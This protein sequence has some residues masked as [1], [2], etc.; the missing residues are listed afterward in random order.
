MHLRQRADSPD[1][2]CCDVPETLHHAGVGYAHN[3]R[4]DRKRKLIFYRKPA[5]HR[6]LKTYYTAGPWPDHKSCFRAICAFLSFLHCPGLTHVCE[7]PF[8]G[9]LFTLSVRIVTSHNCLFP[10]PFL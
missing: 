9:L 5:M 2:D 3:T 6:L 10:L 7:S 1:G 8:E 4:V